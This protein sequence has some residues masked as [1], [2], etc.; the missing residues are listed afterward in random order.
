[1]SLDLTGASLR[2]SP[3]DLAAL[4]EEL[5]DNALSY[6]QPGT[7]VRVSAR[8]D[9]GMLRLSVI[10]LGA[11]MTPEQRQQLDPG[12]K[13]ER[14]AQRQEGVGLGLTLVRKLLQRL[15]GEIS[16]ESEPGKGTTIHILLPIRAA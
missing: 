2:A 8:P 13:K 4:A 11:G 14:E 6:S 7:P 15:G 9:G 3:A 16:L 1:L 10:D 12:D 5:V